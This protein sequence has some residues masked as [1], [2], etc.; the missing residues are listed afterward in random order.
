MNLE[1]IRRGGQGAPADAT[2]SLFTIKNWIPASAGMTRE[3]GDDMKGSDIETVTYV[4][5]YSYST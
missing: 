4:L 1:S 5:T 2:I 3:R